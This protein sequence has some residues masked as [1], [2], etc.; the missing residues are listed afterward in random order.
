M[1]E[2]RI[3][4]AAAEFWR[5]AGM[6]P[7]YPVEM[8]EAILFALPLDIHLIAR[9]SVER[10]GEWARERNIPCRLPGR[11]RRLRGC[12]LARA[13]HGVLFVDGADPR[14]E[15]RF[16][17]AHEAAHFLLDY[18]EPRSRALAALGPSILPVLDGDR[19]PTAR[20]RAH[21]LLATA[22]LGLHA[23]IMERGSHGAY[24]EAAA[25]AECNADR[26][27]L[28]LLAPADLVR[29]MLAEGPGTYEEWL[30]AAGAR[31]V[32]VFGLP[33]ALARGYAR[34]L[35]REQGVRPSVAAWLGLPGK[36]G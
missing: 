19:P 16:T 26:L 30:R 7:V 20:E 32:Q 35:L 29:S 10:V 36:R 13:G 1:L 22:P 23:H 33:P 6:L 31:L 15:Q 8:Q 2:A 11:D 27:A 5:R 18:E 34:A 21:A 17:L 3:G 12:L 24:G 28:E 9:L 25:E 14:D 4:R